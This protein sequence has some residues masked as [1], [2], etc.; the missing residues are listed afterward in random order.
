MATTQAAD[1]STDEANRLMREAEE[2]FGTGDLPRILA[3]FTPDVVVRYADF[4]EMRGR[5]AYEAFL[6]ARVGRQKYYRPRKTLRAVTGNVIIDSW[7]GEWE[8]AQS[9]KRMQGR[10]MECLTMRAGKVV[11][12]EAVFNAWEEGSG[13]SIPIT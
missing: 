5:D 8:D 9:G 12:L 4:P 11:V 13:A 2:A 6:R 7:E 10:G 3:M 1:I